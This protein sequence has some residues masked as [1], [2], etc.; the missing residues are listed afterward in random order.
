ML[1]VA[2]TGK[3]P[4]TVIPTDLF[5]QCADLDRIQAAWDTPVVAAAAEAMGSLYKE[6][7]AGKGA[8]VSVYSFN[9]NKIITTSGGSMP[10]SD[11]KKIVS[12]AHYLA[13]QARDPK[14]CYHRTR[15]GYNYRMSNVLAAMG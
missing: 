6:G 9:S 10:A 8:R 12:Y 4:K 11:D 3:L 7:H 5:G 1:E 14:P 13:N 15:I 2:R